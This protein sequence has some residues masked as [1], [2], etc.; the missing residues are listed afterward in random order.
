MSIAPGK[1]V[2]LAFLVVALVALLA[3]PAAAGGD[4]GGDDKGP[5]LTESTSPP[6]TEGGTDVSVDQETN[7][8]GEDAATEVAGATLPFTGGDVAVI[9]A[10][11]IGLVAAGLVLVAARRRRPDTTV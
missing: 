8:P 10:V 9:A 2:L 11:G 6:V 5:Y 4:A 3:L 1:R 7:D